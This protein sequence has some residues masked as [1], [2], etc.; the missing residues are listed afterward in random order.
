MVSLFFKGNCSSM[1]KHH[2]ILHQSAV[3]E[4]KDTKPAGLFSLCE[5]D[6][7]AKGK[8]SAMTSKW[9]ME[10]PNSSSLLTLLSNRKRK[11]GFKTTEIPTKQ[12]FSGEMWCL[13]KAWG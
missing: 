6:G 8:E 7:K 1:P 11:S 12:R 9:Q 3:R 4:R 2:S 10:N 5:A 13:Q